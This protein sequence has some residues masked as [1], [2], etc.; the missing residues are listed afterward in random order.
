MK[1]STL[2]QVQSST[3]S[4]RAEKATRQNG[5]GENEQYTVH[6]KSFVDHARDF[7]PLSCE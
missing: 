1:F 7:F 2:F 5:T 6:L 4:I 3:G